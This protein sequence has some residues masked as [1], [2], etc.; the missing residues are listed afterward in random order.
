MA[1]YQRFP[2]RVIMASI[3]ERNLIDPES[4]FGE[5]YR[6]LAHMTGDTLFTNQ[7]VEANRFC[8]PFLLSLFPDFEEAQ[9]HLPELDRMIREYESEGVAVDTWV[10]IAAQLCGTKPDA[11]FSVPSLPLDSGWVSLDPFSKLE[12]MIAEGRVIMEIYLDTTEEC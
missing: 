7:I 11:E 6:L 12:K 10:Y 2:F 3:T 4:G 5:L 9:K 8:K 1:T